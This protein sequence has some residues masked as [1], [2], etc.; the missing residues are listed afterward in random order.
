MKRASRPVNGAYLLRMILSDLPSPAEAGFAKAGNWFPSRIKS[1]T[2]FVGIM[3]YLGR[4]GR[5]PPV[6]SRRGNFFLPARSS[7]GFDPSS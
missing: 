6:R 1:G 7:R 3:R 5:G 4:D 2:C